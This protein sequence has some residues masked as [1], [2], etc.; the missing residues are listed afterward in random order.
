MAGAGKFNI[1]FRSDKKQNTI[2]ILFLVLIS[3]I[4]PLTAKSIAPFLLTL[5][6]F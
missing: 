5:K 6:K 1:I 4:Y 2:W 3:E